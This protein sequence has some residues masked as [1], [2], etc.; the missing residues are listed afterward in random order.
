MLAV[1]PQRTH[2]ACARFPHSSCH[3]IRISC[4]KFVCIY[5]HIYIRACVGGGKFGCLC[6]TLLFRVDS[7]AAQSRLDLSKRSGTRSCDNDLRYDVDRLRR[8]SVISLSNAA[9]TPPLVPH[10]IVLSC[11]QYGE[12]A[13]T[14]QVSPHR[15]PPTASNSGPTSPWSTALLMATPSSPSSTAA[16]AT[17]RSPSDSPARHRHPRAPVPRRPP[18]PRLR[19]PGPLRGR[20][21][22]RHHEE[23]GHLRPLVG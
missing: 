2:H 21:R 17:R 10:G 23:D 19:E 15:R 14:C 16:S 6:A 8:R 13:T 1:L 18:R 22:H 12:T 7:C 4:P 3:P 20:V 11:S 9:G 5:I